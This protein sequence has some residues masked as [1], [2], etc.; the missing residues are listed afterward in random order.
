[1]PS[2][3]LDGRISCRRG[4][5]RPRKRQQRRRRGV[6]RRFSRWR[7]GVLGHQCLVVLAVLATAANGV[8]WCNFFGDPVGRWNVSRGTRGRCGHRLGQL[9]G[10]REAVG[11]QQRQQ[12]QRGIG[13][14]G[15]SSSDS[16][17]S[18][19]SGA[20]YENK[21]LGARSGGG[22]ERRRQGAAAR[23]GCGVFWGDTVK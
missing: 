10:L 22:L 17:V 19:A 5:Q 1:M 4:R 21:F 23:G 6:L 14:S 18:A 20:E 9:R 11:V 16:N 7:R 3:P 13:G 8:W 15:V 2:R 12:C